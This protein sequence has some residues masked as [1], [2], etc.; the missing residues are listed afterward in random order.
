VREVADRLLAIGVRQV[1]HAIRAQFGANFSAYGTL[2]RRRAELEYPA[3]PGEKIEQE[4]LSEAI[5]TTE[6]IIE[7]AG[8]LLPHPTIYTG[9]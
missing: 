7:A 3:Y 2:R 1:E 8:K 6:Q 4:E 5:K 9:T